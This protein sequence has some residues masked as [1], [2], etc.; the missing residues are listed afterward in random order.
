M[1]EKI[2]SILKT[3]GEVIGFLKNFKVAKKELAKT[4]VAS[5]D[6]IEDDLAEELKKYDPDKVAKAAV[7]FIQAKLNSV[8]DKWL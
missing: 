6:N 3:V 8:I 7:D 4:L 1:I 2:K 5:L